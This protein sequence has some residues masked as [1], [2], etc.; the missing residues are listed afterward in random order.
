MNQPTASPIV[1][2]VAPLGNSEEFREWLVFLVDGANVHWLRG[3][4]HVLMA[5][6]D[7]RNLVQLTGV[8]ES[9]SHFSDFD[10]SVYFC[11]LA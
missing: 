9:Y 10:F 11:L 5:I 1:S 8:A 6:C 4:C 7:V 2:L 3:Y